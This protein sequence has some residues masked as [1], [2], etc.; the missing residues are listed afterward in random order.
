MHGDH[1][2]LLAEGRTLTVS[3]VR[4]WWFPSRAT[5]EP[6]GLNAYIHTVQLHNI[7]K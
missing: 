4:S 6:R 3:A 7:Q 5:A 2:H 1:V